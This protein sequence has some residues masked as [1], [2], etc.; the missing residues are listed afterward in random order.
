MKQLKKSIL[1][2]IFLILV[3]AATAYMGFS[4]RSGQVSNRDLPESRPSGKNNYI[5]DYAHILDDIRS[6]TGKYLAIIKNDY[7]IETLIVTLPSLPPSHTIESLAA[8]MFSNWQIGSTTEG[9]GLLLLLSDKEKL[10]K[11][12]VSYE[13]EDVFTDIFCGYIEDKQLK[14]YFLSNQVDIGLVAVMEEIEQRAQIR[15]QAD[16][17]VAQIDELDAELLS[18]GA[19]AKRQL[20]D[21][22]EEEISTVGQT[23]PAGHTADE[24]WHTLIRSWQDKVRDPNLG[25]YT[26]I[27]RLAYREFKNLPDSRY[28]ED[29][30]TY[31]NK[32]Y[33]VIQND[34]YAVIFFGKKKGWDNAPFLFCRTAAGW[35]FD[36]V[37]QRKYVRM[38]RN[39]HWG[40]ERSDYPYV[41]LLAKC[42]YWMNQDIPWEGDDIYRIEDDSRLADEILE[43]EQAYESRPED[44]ATVMHLGKL[45]TLTSL[46][47]KKRISFLKK[48][49]QLD[50]DSP[51]PYKY[52]G[53]V[54]LDAFYQFDS[55]IKE[56]E[57]YVRRR[58]EDVFGHNYLGYLYYCEKHYNPAIKELNK[59]VQLKADNCYAYAKLSRTYAGLFL[60]SSDLDPRRAGY[61]RKAVM[62]FEKASATESADP[63]R[64]KWLQRYLSKKKILE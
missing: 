62:M 22:R 44:F 57:A 59:A 15:H 46:G 30:N 32:P 53:I 10:I 42:P 6:S 26:R 49:K 58:P 17:T 25:V 41:N 36:I 38:G 13:L 31:K 35:Q 19:G 51:E 34:T 7:A 63:R 50:P 64:I 47:P 61:R 43:L 11:I 45:Y 8:E 27:T 28:E 52:L 3:L 12:E 48:A 20:T 39:P 21:Y 29:V 2:K 54:H 33:E 4:L 37:H 24:A 60:D 18:G 9:R 16:Y 14:G 40:I 23:Y 1:V 55:A 56:M 5:F